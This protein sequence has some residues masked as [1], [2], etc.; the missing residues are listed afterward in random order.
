MKYKDIEYNE[1]D[2]VYPPAEDTFLLIDNLDVK[3]NDEVLEIG[4]GSGIVSIAAS[5]KAKNVTSVDINP[6]AIKCTEAN[7]KLNN[8]TNIT[9]I[10]SDLFENINEKYD[11]ILFNTPYLPVVEEEHDPNDDYAKAW[12]GGID[13]RSVINKF[14][15]EASEY[16]KTN[17]KIQLVQSSLSDNEKTLNYLNNNGYTAEITAKEHQFF[18]DITLITAKKLE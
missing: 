3:E 14:L 4:V 11:L 5:Y 2:E 7:I 12:D 1:C 6:N 10:E 8:V 13:G 17:G 18:E 16:L 15:E 9:T